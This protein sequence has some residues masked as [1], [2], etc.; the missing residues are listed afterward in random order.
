MANSIDI[1]YAVI[2]A[3]KQHARNTGTKVVRL[4]LD[5]D[6]KPTGHVTLRNG[7][8]ESKGAFV[9]KDGNVKITKKIAKRPRKEQA[10]EATD[11][12]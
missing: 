3:A 11:S 6:G 12:E 9:V 1:D 5:D 2:R 10:Q 4:A 8:G 7:R